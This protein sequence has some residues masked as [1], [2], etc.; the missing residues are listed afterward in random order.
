[1]MLLIV[2]NE[3]REANKHSAQLGR[4]YSCQQEDNQQKTRTTNIHVTKLAE[5]QERVKLNS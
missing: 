1:M 5:K 2:L 4:Q 3:E